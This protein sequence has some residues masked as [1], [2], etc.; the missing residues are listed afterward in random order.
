MQELKVFAEVGEENGCL[1]FIF[2]PP[3]L[4]VR[5]ETLEAALESA[6]GAAHELAVLMGNCWQPYVLGNFVTVAE[7]ILRRGKVANGN[8][9]VTFERD[10]IPP[11]RDDITMFLCVLEKVRGQLLELKD[12]IPPE[13]YYFRSLPHRKTIL[14]QMSHIAACDR[15]YLSRLWK[16]IPRLK[17]SRG[18]WEKLYLNRMRVQEKLLDLGDDDLSLVVRTDGEIW[19]CTKLLRR[20]MYHERFH[21]ATIIRDLALY[22]DQS[23]D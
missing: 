10:R 3:G 5:G 18:V 14:E 9:S 1:L 7:K 4:L 2:D 15:W 16:G 19:T 8:T 23:A 21:L 11:S 6:P 22:K 12:K 20:L 17:P 13:A